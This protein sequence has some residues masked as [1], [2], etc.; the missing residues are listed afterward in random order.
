MSDFMQFI[1]VPEQQPLNILVSICK[2]YYCSSLPVTAGKRFLHTAEF[3]ILQLLIVLKDLVSGLCESASRKM[4]GHRST[5]LGW[6][7]FLVVICL[8]LPWL[9]STMTDLPFKIA[10]ANIFYCIRGVCIANIS[11]LLWVVT[12]FYVYLYRHSLK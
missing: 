8:R 11:F 9:S 1:W 7:C 3:C 12:Y 5:L 2:M 6:F 4:W 10:C